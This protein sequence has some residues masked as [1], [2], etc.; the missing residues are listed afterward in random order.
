M[1]GIGVLFPEGRAIKSLQRSF[2]GDSGGL[3]LAAVGLQQGLDFST[4]SELSTSRISLSSASWDL[5]LSSDWTRPV[6]FPIPPLSTAQK[7]P[8]GRCESSQNARASSDHPLPPRKASPTSDR[9][10]SS[11]PFD[12]REESPRKLAPSS[13]RTRLLRQP[14]LRSG[15]Y[16]FRRLSFPSFARRKRKRKQTKPT[17]EDGSRQPA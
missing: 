8:P 16:P 1:R 14:G 5:K 10:A 11:R 3:G 4:F 12:I 7:K 2:L 17:R 6:T 9:L 13:L 15:V